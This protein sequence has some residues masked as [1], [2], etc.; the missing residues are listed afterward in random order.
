MNRRE[1]SGWLKHWDF[2]LL[3]ILGMQLSFAIAFWIVHGFRN[4]YEQKDY[5][6]QAMVLVVSQ[7]LTILFTRQYSGVL[8]RGKFRE[9]FE[10]LK[11]MLLTLAI[12]LLYLFITKNSAV[13]SRLQYGLTS[14]LFIGIAFA[15]RQLNKKRIALHNANIRNRRSIVLVT[16]RSLVKDAIEKLNTRNG[17]Q[18][19]FISGIILL[20]GQEGD[21]LSFDSVTT[22]A[23]GSGNLKGSNIAS[24]E[25]AAGNGASAIAGAEAAVGVG[26][27]AIADAEAAGKGEAIPVAVL[28]DKA[29]QDLVHG[30]VDEVFILQPEGLEFPAKLVDSLMVM[31]I[32]VSYTMS[33]LTESGWSATEISTL[34]PY[35]VLTNSVRFISAGEYGLKRLLDIIGGAIG[36]L[37]TGILCIFV[38]PAIYIKSPG[39]IFFTQE[40]VGQNGKPFRM[41]KFRSMYLDAEERKAALMEQNKISDG[42]MFKMDDDPRIIG[43]EKKN[44]NGKPAGIGN[45]IRNT[46]IDEFP[47]FF[48]VLRGRMSLVGWRPCT[49]SE[50]EKYDMKHRIRASMKPGLTGMWQVSGRSNI[51]DFNEVVR[52]DREYIENWSLGL[53]LKILVKTVGVVIR[54]RGAE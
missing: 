53:D 14:V 34:G 51:T 6:Y 7:I 18:D 21:D 37:I 35:K 23:A 43:S 13:A 3:D 41:H 30:W 40:R 19:Y 50:W 39:S 29:V 48:D 9:L 42:M 31:G 33:S 45:F 2:I 24:V 10:V 52:L 36:C 28:G 32:Q 25:A 15:L 27:S 1:N 26:A 22:Y 20:D 11:H 54:G 16:G 49:M 47:Q 44:R 4:P 38:G 12:A 5:Q 17:W 8:R 46:S